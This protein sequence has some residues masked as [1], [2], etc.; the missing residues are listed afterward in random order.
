MWAVSSTADPQKTGYKPNREDSIM[1]FDSKILET[2]LHQEEG[3]ALDFK[4]EQYPFENADKGQK[5][6][7]LK[8]I[9]ALANSW[10]L[11]T[12]YILIGVKEVKG[13]RSEIV[14]VESHLDDAS[15]HQFVNTKTQ[16]PVDFSYL[17]FRTEGV[18]IGVIEIPIQERPIF[19]TGRYGP[20]RENEVPIRDGSSTRTASPDEIAKIGVGQA[21]SDAPQLTL[22]WAA[23]DYRE[24]FPSPHTI[25][26]S[27]LEPKLP[28][29]PFIPSRKADFVTY[30]V[31]GNFAD[32]ILACTTERELL[33]GRGFRLQNKSGI[34]GRRI[35]FSARTKKLNGMVIQESIDPL[36][37][38]Y[39]SLFHH[40]VPDLTFQRADDPVWSFREFDRFWEIIVDFGDVRPHDEIWTDTGLFLG[41]LSP[42]VISLQ[43]ELRGDNIPE[44]IVCELEVKV[45]VE[46][47][48][49]TKDDVIAYLSKAY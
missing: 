10:R 34:V 12:A 9:L 4:Q 42:C 33:T 24:V 26:S 14:G 36:P 39:Y 3:T 49:M 41:S 29:E 32:E 2:L 7:L 16:R 15:L 38:P 1:A 40:D 11:V 28:S 8:D 27:V 21:L 23:L 25:H 19:L 5:A 43:G 48:A 45:N 18:E 6:E 17:P 30:S 37:S 44:P 46:R 22:E 35:R 20:L 31:N 13:G 47:R